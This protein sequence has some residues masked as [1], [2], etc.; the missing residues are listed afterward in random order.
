M[1]TYPTSGIKLRQTPPMVFNSTH[2]PIDPLSMALMLTSAEPSSST[3]SFGCINS[4][5]CPPATILTKLS[6]NTFIDSTAQLIHP[7]TSYPPMPHTNIDHL[8]IPFDP[9]CPP[10]W[11]PSLPYWLGGGY[12]RSGNG[13]VLHQNGRTKSQNHSHC[14]MARWHI[15]SLYAQ[16][17]QGEIIDPEKWDVHLWCMRV[18]RAVK[19]L[20]QELIQLFKSCTPQWR[21][22]RWKWRQ[23]GMDADEAKETIRCWRRTPIGIHLRHFPLILIVFP[24]THHYDSTDALPWL[25][26]L[27]WDKWLSLIV[28][29]FP[30]ISYYSHDE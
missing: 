17:A 4:F 20:W 30:H 12:L 26:H 23:T 2:C 5:P 28:T 3:S 10:R 7:S 18:G 25:T 15:K 27:I 1:H 21:H 9:L 16:V 14:N 22:W 29:L 19:L 24:M 11:Q 6:T 13:H 8:Y